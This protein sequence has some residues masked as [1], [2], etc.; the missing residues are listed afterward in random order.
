MRTSNSEQETSV[1]TTDRS[2]RVWSG[3]TCAQWYAAP[4]DEEVER[5]ALK[6]SHHCTDQSDPDKLAHPIEHTY[7]QHASKQAMPSLT[8]KVI[9][10]SGTQLG[11]RLSVRRLAWRCSSCCCCRVP[12]TTN[13]RNASAATVHA[14]TPHGRPDDPADRRHVIR[15]AE[16]AL[17]ELQVALAAASC[18]H[19]QL[20]PALPRTA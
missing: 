6:I 8:S 15:V 2:D 4:I 11:R 5:R 3:A 19:S 7:S 16:I 17:A 1:S 14:T 20:Q 9:P 18:R 13:K 10:P 12:R